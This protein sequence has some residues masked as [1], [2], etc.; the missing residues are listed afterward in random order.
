L[1]M[2]EVNGG[3]CCIFLVGEL[4]KAQKDPKHG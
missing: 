2:P 4:V 1:R 3:G